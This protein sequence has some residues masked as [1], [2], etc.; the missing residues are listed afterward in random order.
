[1]LLTL[2][3]LWALAL[4]LTSTAFVGLVIAQALARVVRAQRVEAVVAEPVPG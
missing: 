3:L 4:G 2:V 1:M